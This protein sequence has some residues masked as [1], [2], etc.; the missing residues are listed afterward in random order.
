MSTSKD[1]TYLGERLPTNRHNYTL[2]AGLAV[3]TM[4]EIEVY[5]TGG[6]GHDQRETYQ[7]ETKRTGY[8]NTKPNTNNVVCILLK[9]TQLTEK[10][11]QFIESIEQFIE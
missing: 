11:E 7:L 4:L 5:Q 2:T 10:M 8:L 6:A 1:N 3:P 9:E